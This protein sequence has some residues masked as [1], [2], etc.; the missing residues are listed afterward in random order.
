[1]WDSI[2]GGCQPQP[3]WNCI[4]SIPQMTKIPKSVANLAGGKV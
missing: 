2:W 1:M 3:W 4:I